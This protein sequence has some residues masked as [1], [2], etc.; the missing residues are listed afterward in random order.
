MLPL[1]RQKYRLLHPHRLHEQIITKLHLWGGQWLWQIFSED[2]QI[3]VM[4]H[5]FNCSNLHLDFLIPTKSHL[6]DGKCSWLITTN[7]GPLL[8]AERENPTG[9]ITP[10]APSHQ[11]STIDARFPLF[12][13]IVLPPGML[14]KDT[15]RQMEKAVSR[16][17]YPHIWAWCRL[18]SGLVEDSVPC[19]RTGYVR[20]IERRIRTCNYDRGCRHGQKC[21]PWTRIIRS[22]GS[23]EW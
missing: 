13:G 2:M 7:R 21:R 4:C 19:V 22:R 11:V 18:L 3:S 17:N 15:K 12:R 6:L 9:N 10:P 14:Q 20:Q 5:A 8:A 16:Y 23:S 1:F